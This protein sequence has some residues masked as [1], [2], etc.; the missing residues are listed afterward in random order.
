MQRS[1]VRAKVERILYHGARRGFRAEL[2]ARRSFAYRTGPAD[3]TRTALA[4]P[5]REFDLTPSED[6]QMLQAAA[7]D[8]ADGVIRP[9]AAQA[10]ADR[11]VPEK[12]R[13]A[14]RSMGLGLVGVP[15]VLDGIAEERSALTMALVM[16]ELARGDMGIAV[17]LLAPAAVAAAL[18]S[19]GSADQQAT[20]LPAFTG[21]DSSVA[22][23]LAFMEPQPLYDPLKPRT[24]ARTDGDVMVVDGVKAL[25][26]AADVA[27]L[28]VVSVSHDGATRLV[29]VESGT[30]GMSTEDDPAMGLRAAATRR[31]VLTGV[32]V[33]R[34]N[35]LGTADDLVDAVRRSRL[36]WAAAAVGTSQAVLDQVV[37]Y[38]KQRRAFGEPIGHR[39]AVAFAVAD[40]A[41]ELAGLRLL[42]W[43]AASRLD[44]GEDASAEIAQARQLAARYG[45]QIG[46]HGIQ[47]LGGHGFVKEFDNER[48]FR[49]LR[50]AGVLE[51]TLLL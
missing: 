32:R 47:L 40:I 15:A 22:A 11:A 49:D 4:R 21:N 2:V 46:S 19:Y 41:I 23:A 51:G 36:A 9:A 33:P 35:L 1:E 8:L 43:K 16:E 6:Q 24:T 20:Y 27:D 31:L 39:Q 44:R 50:A 3:P 14:A 42:V 5:G 18:A 13:A 10:D 25:V 45:A 17:S 48:W 30:A 29:I 26:P 37:P 38:V 34:S 12:V 28:F 7:H